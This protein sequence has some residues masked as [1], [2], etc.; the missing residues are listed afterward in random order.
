[1]LA[2]YRFGSY[3]PAPGVNSDA[4][5][6]LLGDQAGVLSLL[7]LFSG[8]GLQRLSIFALG[9][10]PYITASIIL[11]VLTP[12]FPNLQALQKE[13]ELGQR[14]ITQ[15]T[16]YLTVGLAFAQAAGYAYLFSHP[17]AIS[18]ASSS[19]IS[20][21]F[22]SVALI[23]TTLTAGATLLM[24]IGELIPQ[25]GI[26]NGMS[27][28]IFASILTSAPAGISAWWNG[29]SFEK[30]SLP[31]VV[32][33]IVYSVVYV[34]EGIRKIPIQYAKRM[35]GRRM[36]QGGSTYLPLRVNM[37]GVIPIIFATA[38]MAFPST[39]AQFSAFATT[40]VGKF[41]TNHLSPSSYT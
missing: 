31:L 30:L 2:V 18:G 7:T 40:S 15:Y 17:G 4:L 24:W 6:N 27:L 34:Q 11:Q 8:G 13:G 35:V 28:L 37:A 22:R 14:R 32:L 16:R 26:G 29:S 21:D 23:I 9:I 19:L 20:T 1:M 25:R 12:V 38:L 3:L 33:G 41:F 5:S 39:F 36:T 10:M